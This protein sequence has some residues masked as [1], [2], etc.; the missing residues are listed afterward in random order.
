MAWKYLKHN[1]ACQVPTNLFF[2]D[3]E[4]LPTQDPLLQELQ[5][6]KLRLGVSIANRYEKL[7]TTRRKIYKFTT[8]EQFWTQLEERL[9]PRLPLYVYAHN[10][11]FD[12]TIVGF[13]EQLTE[14]RFYIKPIGETVEGETESERRKRMSGDILCIDDPPTIVSCTHKNGCKVIFLDTLNYWRTSLKAMGGKEYD[15]KLTMPDFSAS[16]EDWFIYCQRDVE[17]VERSVLSLISLVKKQDLGNYRMTQASQAI[18]AFRHRFMDHEICLHNELPVKHLERKAY[19]GGQI[20]TGFIGNVE[21]TVHKLDVKSMYPGVMIH[22]LFPWKLHKYEDGEPRRYIGQINSSRST[23]AE[24]FLDTPVQVFPLRTKKGCYYVRGKFWTTLCG[25]ELSYAMHTNV[26]KKVGRIATY[27]IAKLFTSY[28]EYFWKLREKFRKEG[29]KANEGLCK[30][31]LNS[32]YGKFGQRGQEW[33]DLP[34][35]RSGGP[36]DYW[37]EVTAGTGVSVQYRTINGNVQIRVDAGEHPKAFPAIAAWVTAYGRKQMIGIREIAGNRNWYYQ[38]VDSIYVSDE[39][40]RR[41]KAAEMVKQ[42]VLGYLTY[43]GS[44]DNATFLGPN[45]YIF[46]ND[47]TRGSIKPNAK[48]VEDNLFEQLHFSHIEDCLKHGGKSAVQVKT[49]RKRLSH[50]FDRGVV[51]SEGWVTPLTVNLPDYPYSESSTS[52]VAI[53]SNI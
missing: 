10:L 34:T 41:L 27:R 15:G 52:S 37:K 30:L 14:G 48:E 45:Q 32:L 36:W 12:L 1:K 18:G 21:G 44:T 2:F 26:V 13:W 43:E 8:I 16:N 53:P 5:H 31:F 4:T 25:E 28:V 20:E 11:G 51:S 29:D 7:I 23:I 40:L 50:K 22:G 6:H 42:G 3:T 33:Q 24:V 19:Y 9:H 35:K 39:G 38:A 46:G 17:I 49:V 47:I